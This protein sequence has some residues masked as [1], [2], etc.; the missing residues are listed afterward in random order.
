MTPVPTINIDSCVSECDAKPTRFYWVGHIDKDRSMGILIA[1]CKDHLNRVGLC[2]WY[3]DI[4]E[5]TREEA[6]VW[7]VLMS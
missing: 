1:A 3:A 6:I 7:S 5:M 4:V 2:S